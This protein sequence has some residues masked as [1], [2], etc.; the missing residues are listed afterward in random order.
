MKLLLSTAILLASFHSFGQYYYKDIVGTKESTDLIGTYRA[1]KVSA[2]VLNS[3]DGNNTRIDNFSIQQQFSPQALV[4]I[5]KTEAANPSVLTT[6]Y[7]V[8]GR[9]VKTVDSTDIMVSTSTYSYNAAGQLTSISISS[10]DSAHANNQFE[11]HVWQ[12]NGDKVIRMLR[13][14]NKVDTTYVDF[15]LDKNGNVIEE[16]ETH[17]GVKSEPV[18]YYYD[19]NNR[20]TDIVRFNKR[21]QKLLPEYM[22]E[23]S[24][25]NQVIQKITVPENNSEYIIWR[26]QFDSKGLIV[27]EA[28]YNKQKELTG[29]IEYQ[30][31]FGG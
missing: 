20:L 5:T 6:Y 3:Y 29:K 18:Y 11:E 31:S 15:K 26:Y 8:N 21:A 16:D 22:F 27:K 7:D 2:V 25:S 9:I 24:T 19:D 4:T 30:Y 23:Y 12:Y 28:I 10:I 1:N 17:K 14:K 13:I